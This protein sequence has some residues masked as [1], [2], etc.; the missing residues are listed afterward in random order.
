[1]HHAAWTQGCL[2]KLLAYTASQDES[3]RGPAIRL[4]CG[5][6]VELSHFAGSIEQEAVSNL[7]R[8]CLLEGA[9][10]REDGCLVRHLMHLFLSLCVHKHTLLNNLLE[11]YLQ[12]TPQVRTGI[13]NSISDMIKA[14]GPDSTEL[15]RLVET[16]P[17]GSEVLLLAFVRTLTEGGAAHPKIT[18]T[19]KTLYERKKD[20]RFMIYI[21]GGL[22]KDELLEV[23]PNIVALPSVG[24]KAA[25]QRMLHARPA[26]LSPEKLIV[27]LHKLLPSKALP[28]KKIAEAIEYCFGER[29]IF[30]TQVLAVILQQLVD[31]ESCVCARVRARACVLACR[32]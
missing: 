16:C 5:K 26:P 2:K 8:A 4:V 17:E 13:Q 22:P 9:G 11:A 27:A 15:L 19:I 23:L 10:G 28:M 30:T 1:M 6:I 29:S 12:S 21:V 31:R 20:A 18:E 24:A 32:L 3:L 7:R 25:L 14:I